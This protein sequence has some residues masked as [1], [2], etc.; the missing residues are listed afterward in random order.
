MTKVILQLDTLTCPSCM[1]K[2]QGAL[3]KLAGVQNVKVL[4]NAS[5]VKAL[6]DDWLDSTDLK[7]TVEELG[8][9]VKSV[10]TKEVTE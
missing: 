8:Y 4:F 7:R 9:Q 3:T 6:V 1:T 10:K 5:K 2:I